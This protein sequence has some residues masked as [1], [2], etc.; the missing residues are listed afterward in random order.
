MIDWRELSLKRAYCPGCTRRWF[1]K[2]DATEIAV[3][4]LSCQASSITIE[5]AKIKAD[6]DVEHLTEQKF[7]AAV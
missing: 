6:R 2:L 1:I 3:R 4:C 7:G 5:R